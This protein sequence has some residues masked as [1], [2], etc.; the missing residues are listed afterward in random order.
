MGWCFFRFRRRS[1]RQLWGCCTM[2]GEVCLF[3]RESGTYRVKCHLSINRP[4]EAKQA[5][6]LMFIL[7]SISL[8]LKIP[9][10]NVDFRSKFHLILDLQWVTLDQGRTAH[11][12]KL[13]PMDMIRGL[14]RGPCRQE[15]QRGDQTCGGPY[16]D[17]AGRRSSC[18]SNFWNVR[19]RC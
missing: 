10:L 8:F 5:K 9:Y 14:K 1:G 13:D 2:A 16:S 3:S 6:I 7:A 15:L 11:W 12:L 19:L 4:L 18:P 17:C